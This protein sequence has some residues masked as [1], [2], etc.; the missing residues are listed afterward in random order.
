[1]NKPRPIIFF[2]GNKFVFLLVMLLAAGFALAWLEHGQSWLF[3]AVFLV[4]AF[5]YFQANKQIV[6]YVNYK[7][8][9]DA[10]GNEDAV[11]KSEKPRNAKRKQQIAFGVLLW[12]FLGF[13]LLKVPRANDPQFYD[14]IL[15]VV[16]ALT[17]WLG[18]LLLRL[19]TQKS[20]VKI[21][22]KQ[23][24]DYIVNQ[25]QPVPRATATATQIMGQ[26]PSYCKTLLQHKP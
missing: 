11:N 20:N 16:I 13:S 21:S 15:L 12:G 5:R 6:A 23:Q 18:Y 9:W 14:G 10:A 22:T 8:A 1:M 4:M 24:G 2:I 3:P 26:L 7:R 17:L 25:C 19:R